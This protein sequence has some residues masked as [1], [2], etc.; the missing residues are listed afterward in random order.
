VKHP[1][2]LALVGLSASLLVACE[3]E[4]DKQAKE[5]KRII[6]DISSRESAEVEKNLKAQE[7][8]DAKLSDETNAKKK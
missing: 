8:F 7:E 4:A 6:K 5:H 3:S 2:L 1:F